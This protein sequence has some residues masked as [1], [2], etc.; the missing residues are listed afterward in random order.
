[1]APCCFSK[2]SGLHLPPHRLS[3]KPLSQQATPASSCIPRTLRRLGLW[4][5]WQSYWAPPVN[6]QLLQFIITSPLSQG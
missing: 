2:L 5:P 1:M 3:T 4:L 6:P